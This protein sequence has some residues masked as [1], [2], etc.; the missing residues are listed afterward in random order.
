MPVIALCNLVWSLFTIG[1]C[2]WLVFAR[3]ESSWWFLLAIALW[4]GGLHTFE[5]KG[6]A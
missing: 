4:V 5:K 1:G 6:S 3:G 2:G